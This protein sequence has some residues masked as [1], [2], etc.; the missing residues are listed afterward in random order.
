MP[1]N[2]EE[3]VNL[4][5]SLEKAGFPVTGADEDVIYA[6]LSYCGHGFQPQMKV[7][8]LLDRAIMVRDEIVSEHE[9]M[10]RQIGGRHTELLIAT[11]GLSLLRG[12]DL[13]NAIAGLREPLTVDFDPANLPGTLVNI[14]S[15]HGFLESLEEFRRERK[16]VSR[17]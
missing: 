4:V 3:P 8:V 13:G 17:G 10:L 14:L 15:T 7:G 12:N 5:K 11:A 6:L 2:P 16:R 9:K 1:F